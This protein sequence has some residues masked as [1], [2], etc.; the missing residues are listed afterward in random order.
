MSGSPLE[1]FRI[2]TLFDI[3][4]DFIPGDYGLSFTNSSLFMII[5]ISVVSFLLYVAT[6]QKSLVPSRGQLIAEGLYKLTREMITDNT[7]DAGLKFFPLIFTLFM[8]ILGCNLLGMIPYS[9]TVTSHIVINFFIAFTILVLITM[10]GFARHGLHFLKLFLPD[11][12]PILIAPLILMIEIISYCMRPVSL[13]LRLTANMIAGHTMLK[14]IATIILSFGLLGGILPFLFLAALNGFELF[15][16]FLQAYI[17][18][19]L[20]CVYLNDA[21]NLH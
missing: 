4:A 16:A 21:I 6:K 15:I 14:V 20:V 3:P 9:F 5:T 19:L 17:F 8:F 13:S 7:G 1:Q 18:S 11:G 12:I 10:L 2:K